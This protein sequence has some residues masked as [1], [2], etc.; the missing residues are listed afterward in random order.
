MMPLS[1]R[2]TLPLLIALAA[3]LPSAASSNEPAGWEVQA[4]ERARAVNAE[5]L[6]DF[7][8][9]ATFGPEADQAEAHLLPIGEEDATREALLIRFPCMRAAYNEVYVFVLSDRH[10]QVTPVFFPSPRVEVR[11]VDDDTERGVEALEMGETIDAREVVNPRYDPDSR[12]MEE[13][14]MWRGLGDARSMTR[15]GFRDGRFQIM[16]LDVDATY[17]GEVN[18]VTLIDRDIW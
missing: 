3:F 16:R 9:P 11:Y 15:W 4:F 1:P 17:D 8:E 5:T 14:R 7:C 18:P 6:P 10:G 2:R 13:H 12:T